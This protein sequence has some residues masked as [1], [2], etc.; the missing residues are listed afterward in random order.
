[1]V[2]KKSYFVNTA[3]NAAILPDLNWIGLSP[4]LYNAKPLIFVKVVVCPVTG[5]I[6]FIVSSNSTVNNPW[7]LLMV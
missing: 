2:G 4:L 1:M 3:V 7:F 5:F 6:P